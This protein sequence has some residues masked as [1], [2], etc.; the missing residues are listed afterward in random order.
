MSPTNRLVCRVLGVGLRDIEVLWLAE[1]GSWRCTQYMFWTSPL[2]LGGRTTPEKSSGYGYACNAGLLASRQ[3]PMRC[4]CTTSSSQGKALHNATRILT[5]HNVTHLSTHVTA[6]CTNHNRRQRRGMA[7]DSGV[8]HS[9]GWRQRSGRAA[10]SPWALLRAGRRRGC[11][12]ET[13]TA[14]AGQPPK[15]VVNR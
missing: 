13:G 2:T 10:S 1:C 6:A 7:S 8:R 15:S 14:A 3:Q 11:W 5:T 12:P 4:H 9:I